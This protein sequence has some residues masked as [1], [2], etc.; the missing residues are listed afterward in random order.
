[1]SKQ[2]IAMFVLIIHD[3]ELTQK[4]MKIPTKIATVSGQYGL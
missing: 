4:D 2:L 1:M 3:K